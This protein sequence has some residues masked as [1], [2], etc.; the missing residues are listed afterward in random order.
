MGRRDSWLIGLAR[1]RGIC[2]DG[3]VRTHFRA[4]LAIIASSWIVASCGTPQPLEVKTYLLRDQSHGEGGGDPMA[5]NER[6]RR[7]HGAVSIDERR[8]RLGQY[9][10]VRWHD[11]EG[12]GRAPVTVV[13]EYQ[14]GATASRVMRKSATFPADAPGGTA[15]FEVT[16]DDYFTGGRVLAWRVSLRRGDTVVATRQSYLWQ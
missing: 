2:V 6:L 8:A 15:E 13:F 5:R 14:Q 10:S 12:A 7:M 9:Y 16:G 11:A 3:V 1:R 4:G